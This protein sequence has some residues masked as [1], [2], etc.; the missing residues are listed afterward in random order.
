MRARVGT[1]LASPPLQLLTCTTAACLLHTLTHLRNMI[2]E[3]SCSRR[4]WY[5]QSGWEGRWRRWAEACEIP[6]WNK[7]APATRDRRPSR[8][9][10]R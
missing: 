5:R 8:R 10:P 9:S 7:A 2:A 3:K 4:S 6:P 1:G